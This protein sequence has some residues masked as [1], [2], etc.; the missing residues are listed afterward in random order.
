MQTIGMT[1][2]DFSHP[3]FVVVL[4]LR[5]PK[6]RSLLSV[7]EHFEL[8]REPLLNY[9]SNST[10]SVDAGSTRQPSIVTLSPVITSRP[11]VSPA[12]ISE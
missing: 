6:N 11:S 4:G 5:S 2:K 3:Q 1:K 10:I 9:R 8:E 7:N 12:L